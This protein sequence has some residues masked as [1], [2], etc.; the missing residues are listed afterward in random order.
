MS[1]TERELSLKINRYLCNIIGTE[2]V[3]KTRRKIFCAFD[4]VIRFPNVTVISS[5]SKAEGLDLKGSDYDQM[6]VFK[7]FEV[8]EN[9]SKVSSFTNKKPIIMDISDTKPGFT[10]LKL[11]NILHRYPRHINQCVEIVEGETYIS[12]KLFRENNLPD[13]MI[14]HGPCHSAQDETYDL[15]RSFRC[16]EWIT[17]SHQ[18]I[19]RSR[20]SWPDHRLIYNM[21]KTDR[22]LSIKIFQYLCNIIGTEEVVKTRRKLFCAFDSVLRIL[23]HTVISSGSKAEGLDLNGSDYDQMFIYHLFQ[24]YENK[25]KVSSFANNTPIIMDSSDTK[26]G[27][28]KL[29]LYKP[30]HIYHIN[31]WG[32]SVNE[33]TYISSKL[34]REHDVPDNMIIHGPCQSLPGDYYDMARCLRCE[35]WIT[36]AHQWV[37]RSRSSWPDHRLVLSIVKSTSITSIVNIND[38]E[39]SRHMLS[40][41]SINRMQS[42]QF[43]NFETSNKLV[44]ELYQIHSLCFKAGLY[45][46]A[47]SAWSLLASLFYKQKRFHESKDITNY[48]LSKCTPDK[49][50]LPFNNSLPEQTYFQKVK[51]AVGLLLTCKHL[52]IGMVLFTKPYYLLPVELFPLIQHDVRKKTFGIPAV[53]YLN[54]LSFLCVYHLGDNRGK[55]NALRDLELTIRERYFILPSDKEVEMANNC[56][57]IA[58]SMM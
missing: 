53:V 51:E 42:P 17:P 15:A 46:D 13:G 48:T 49:I 12:S 45:F 37:F 2:E 35:E 34:F 24:V 26:P 11:N 27:F 16:R 22:E 14:I 43:N 32:E 50:M 9:M 19:F 52:I 33:E 28:T 41:F 56:F 3:V 38:K 21:S 20:S 31:Q 8:Y 10:K 40:L 36:P 57:Q 23:N 30:R 47:I 4:S 58:K 25:G 18:W 1:T 55:L 44:Y 7:N 5:G 54:M 39:L 6:F 29:K